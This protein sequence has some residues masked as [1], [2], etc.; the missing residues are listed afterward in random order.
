MREVKPDLAIGTTPLVQKAKE[1]GIPAIYFTNMV[2]ARPLFGVAGAAAIPAIVATQ[3]KGG[4]RFARMVEFFDGVG[5][6]ENTGYGWQGEP[7]AHP[8]ARARFRKLREA[9]AKA[10]ANQAMGS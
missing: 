7:E 10:A 1:L 2:S 3:T 4:N 5:T 6:G 9:K 8:E